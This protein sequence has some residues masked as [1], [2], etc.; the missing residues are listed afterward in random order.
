MEYVYNPP[1]GWV[2]KHPPGTRLALLR[3]PGRAYPAN[4]GGPCSNRRWPVGPMV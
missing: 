3:F 4:G 2:V 1:L